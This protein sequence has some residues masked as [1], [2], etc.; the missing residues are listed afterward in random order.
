LAQ[1]ELGSPNARELTTNMTRLANYWQRTRK[2]LT[3]FPTSL[4][5]G[6]LLGIIL[7][8]VLKRPS[9]FLAGVILGV[10]LEQLF[11]GMKGVIEEWKKTRPLRILLGPIAT[12][13]EC[14]IFF[15]SFCRDMSRLN[16]FKLLRWDARQDKREILVTGPD[17]VVGEGDALALA[18]I[19]SLLARIPKKPNEVFVE[20]G[21]EQLD[22]WGVN[23]FCLG[24]HNGKTRVILTKFSKR[25]FTF[26]NNYTVITK[27]DIATEVYEQT[28]EPLRRGV[29]I[30]PRGDA[31]PT[32]YGIILKLRDQFRNNDKVIFVVAGIGP[33]GTSGAAYYLLTQY[34]ELARLGGE[35]GVLV[36]VPSGYQSAHRV[37]FDEVAQ[38]YI[39][40]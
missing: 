24:A 23:C 39:Q 20:R 6:F 29:Y 25:F 35:F 13:E 17:L 27:P 10:I 40:H 15:S 3:S 32:D 12:D 14:Y 31:E 2:W 22:K 37:E 4:V 9:G 16:E 19:Q 36:Q 26:D 30:S 8:L 33:A 21:D 28:K 34:E 1:L 11:L 18:L 5:V 7:A 38:Y